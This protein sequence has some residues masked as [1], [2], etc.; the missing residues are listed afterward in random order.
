MRI[1]ALIDD[2]AVIDRILSCLKIWDSGS[3]AIQRSGRDPP[4]PKGE[5]IQLTCCYVWIQPTP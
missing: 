2:A 5:N 4:R 1:I 3:A